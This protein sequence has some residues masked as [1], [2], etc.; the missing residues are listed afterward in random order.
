M[1]TIGNARKLAAAGLSVWL[2]AGCTNGTPSPDPALSVPPVV[3]LPSTAAADEQTL[4]FLQNRIK[5]DPDDFIAQHKFAAWHLQR[6]RETGDLASAEIAYRQLERLGGIQGQTRVAIDQRLSRLAYLRGDQETAERRM[7]H[8]LKTAQ[9]L[10]VPP[11]ETVA[12]CR[13]QLGEFAFG[14]GNYSAAEQ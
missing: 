10:P 4:R 3:P 14:V 11:R 5:E 1:T 12:W 2:M 9:S 13:W 6:V 8:A 7:L